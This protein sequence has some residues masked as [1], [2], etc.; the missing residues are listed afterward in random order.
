MSER[1]GKADHN[2]L[3]IQD[4]EI[5]FSPIGILGFSGRQAFFDKIP[6][7]PVYPMHAEN[8]ANPTMVSAGGRF[9]KIDEALAGPHRR[10]GC[11]GPTVFD[12]QPSLA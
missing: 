2:S 7:E 3:G 12:L 9:A 6:V 4:F 11:M 1:F 8:Y 10:K 5:P